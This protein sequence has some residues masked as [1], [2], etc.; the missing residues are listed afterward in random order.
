[1][2]ISPGSRYI[3]REIKEKTEIHNVPLDNSL[4][5]LLTSKL[6]E[7]KGKLYFLNV[8]NRIIKEMLEEIEE[9]KSLPLKVQFIL[10][11]FVKSILA[12]R[13]IENI[14]LFGSYSKLIYSDKSDIDV[15]V[16]FKEENE[17]EGTKKRISHIA[18]E[19]SKKHKKEIQEH[20][21]TKSDMKHKEDPLIKDILRNG[22]VLI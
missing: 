17:N 4:A 20:F 12:I 19:I 9:I 6:I 22:K 18:R 1:M 14:I 3:R 11:E 2:T 7:R 10:L 21:F 13:G 8:E 16:I 15:A 5:E